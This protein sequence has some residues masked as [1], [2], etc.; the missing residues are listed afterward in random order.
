[1]DAVLIR[2]EKS[3]R[4]VTTL[5]CGFKM[6]E[7]DSVFG[8]ADGPSNSLWGGSCIWGPIKRTVSN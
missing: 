7:Y 5:A 2:W 8:P 1:M 6:W 4:S 3:N